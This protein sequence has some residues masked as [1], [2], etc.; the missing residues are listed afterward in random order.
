MAGMAHLVE[1]LRV[2]LRSSVQVTVATVG[3]VLLG[4]GIVFLF[5]PGPGLLV[6]IAGLAVLSTQ[7]AWAQTALNRVKERAAQAKAAAARR[8]R[9]PPHPLE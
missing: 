8:R 3:F 9:R 5:L 7:F 6:V 2:L 1:V 4:I